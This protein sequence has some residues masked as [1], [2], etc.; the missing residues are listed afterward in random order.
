MLGPP[1]PLTLNREHKV[2]KHSQE[3]EAGDRVV[4]CGPVPMCLDVTLLS[5]EKQP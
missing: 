4:Q 3:G 1:C 2:S 5:L